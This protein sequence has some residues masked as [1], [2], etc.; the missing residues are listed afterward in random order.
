MK[1]IATR[2]KQ[3]GLS[4]IELMIALTVGL[5]MTGAVIQVYVQ[6]S[7]SYQLQD[8]LSYIQENGRYALS[9]IV[10]ELRMAGYS[11]CGGG[12][13][14][15]NSV[16]SS[17]NVNFSYGLIGYSVDSTDSTVATGAIPVSNYPSL[18]NSAWDGTDALQIYKGDPNSALY[19]TSHVPASATIHIKGTH[20]YLRDTILLIADASCSQIGI[21]SVSGPTNNS[22][23]AN[24]IVHNTGSP[25]S[26]DNCTKKLGGNFTCA[27]GTAED[28]EY[29]KG[30]RV[31]SV[32][33]VLFYI[34]NSGN[35]AATPGLYRKDLDNATEEEVVQ[36]VEDM[37]I[38]FGLDTDG[39]GVANQY[40]TARNVQE[41]QWSNIMSARV[42]L[43]LRSRSTV[44]GVFVRKTLSATTKIRNRGGE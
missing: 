34:R 1:A 38:L 9:E 15:A 5:V 3:L 36:G 41:D 39:D 13:K 42:T 22:A 26:I 27:T 11:S 8:E 6:T 33:G 7:A 23:N 16:E 29:G 19:V 32:D 31:L 18:L 2:P 25:G 17:A 37:V 20:A 10:K 28:K 24:H 44:D 21:F 43:T 12:A 30:S 14:V 4:L 40:L 35:D